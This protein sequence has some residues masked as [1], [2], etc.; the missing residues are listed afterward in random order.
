MP[1]ETL[2]CDLQLNGF[3]NIKLEN[4]LIISEKPNYEI[5][6]SMRLP[7]RKK[8][9]NASSVWKVTND[10][11]EELIDDDELLDEDDL[12]KPDPSSLRV[13]GTTGKR[14][15]CK[16]CACGLAEELAS[17]NATKAPAAPSQK[18][19]CGSVRHKNSRSLS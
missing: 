6:S 2:L 13:C 18:S 15:A 5:G 9:E 17:E 1:K 14:K 12:K 10:E 16:D 3:I 11:E 8:N 4:G 7:Q 19:S